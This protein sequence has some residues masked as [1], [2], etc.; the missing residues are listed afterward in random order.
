MVRS[1]GASASGGGGGV[2]IALSTTSEPA[3]L[4]TSIP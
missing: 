3:K 1:D 2:R 4:T